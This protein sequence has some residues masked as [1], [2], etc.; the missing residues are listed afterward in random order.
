MIRVAHVVTDYSSV[1]TILQ[2]KLAALNSYDDLEVCCISA[3]PAD[4]HFASIAP[5]VPFIAVPMERSI[6][7]RQDVRSI[8]ML[9]RTLSDHA[10]DIVHSHTAKAGVITALAGWRAGLRNVVH[11][12]HGLPFYDGQPR[13]QQWRYRQIEKFACRF[14]RHLFSQNKRDIA[15][16]VGLIGSASQV[17]YEGNGVDVQALIERAEIERPEAECDYPEGELRLCVI[18]RL[19]PVKRVRDFVNACGM[20]RQQGINVVAVIAGQ[21]PQA[22]VLQ[23]M[24]TE[25]GLDPYVKLLGWCGHTAALIGAADVVVLTSEKEGVPRALM[26]AMALSKPVVATDVLGTQ[27]LIVAER[28]GI[29]VPVAQPQALAEAI[30]RLHREPELRRQ[31]GRAGRDRVESEYNDLKIAA[32]LREMY[33]E[34]MS[35]NSAQLK[36]L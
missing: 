4:D 34:F 19:E 10:L 31:F 15:A 1:V 27:E 21:G 25:E 16:C 36:S 11:T 30:A 35:T 13:L 33:Y 23:H 7:P 2:P 18:S 5:P 6:Q 17:S 8:R 32:Y 9:A 12:Y 20:L 22:D 24:I 26:E 28:T 3:P 14:R 29:L